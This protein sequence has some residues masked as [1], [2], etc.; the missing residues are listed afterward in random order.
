MDTDNTI[1]EKTPFRG[2]YWTTMSYHNIMNSYS[3]IDFGMYIPNDGTIGE[4][5]MKWHD[6]AG[7]NV[8]RLEVYN[9]GWGVLFSFADLLE[10]LAELDDYNISEEEFVELLLELGF[11]DLTQYEK[12][13]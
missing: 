8:P 13:E 1:T 7:K 9:D 5:V 11:E 12:P 10:R 3:Q 2:F 6:L 4:M